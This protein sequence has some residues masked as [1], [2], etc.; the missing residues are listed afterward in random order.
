MNHPAVTYTIAEYAMALKISQQT[1][2][3]AIANGE[4][5]TIRFGRSVRIPA[6]ALDA[7]LSQVS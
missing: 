1:V 4:I 3:R 2:R 5:P 7:V 6:S